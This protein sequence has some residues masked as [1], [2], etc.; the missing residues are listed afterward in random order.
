MVVADDG[1][2]GFR[3]EV[4]GAGWKGGRESGG[5]GHCQVPGSAENLVVLDREFRAAVRSEQQ[6]LKEATVR[7]A[8]GTH[9][10]PG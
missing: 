1:R 5:E 8:E 4:A 9:S 6:G 10:F 2:G 3:W 7:L